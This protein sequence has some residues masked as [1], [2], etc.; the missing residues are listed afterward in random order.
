MWHRGAGA[1]DG[2]RWPLLALVGVLLILI[3]G[4]IVQVGML[5][6]IRVVLIVAA[7][8]LVASG[9]SYISLIRRSGGATFRLQLVGGGVGGF[10]SI[11]VS[12]LLVCIRCLSTQPPRS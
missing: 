8:V 10:R 7:V 1:Q 5:E 9:V 3:A 12:H 2:T 11:P 4:E 6:S